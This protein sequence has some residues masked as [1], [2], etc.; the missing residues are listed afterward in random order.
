[1]VSPMTLNIRPSVS[2]PTG[3]WI[4]APVART[5]SPRRT[6]S[7]VSI[8]MHAHR[9][10]AEALLHLEHEA[11][12]ALAI[13]LERVENLRQ[14]LA[15]ELDVDDRTDHLHDGAGARFQ[16][17]NCHLSPQPS[18]AAAPET[19][20]INSVVIDACRTLL[21]VRVRSSMKSLALSDA[22]RIATM[23][24]ACSDGAFSSTAR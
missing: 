7:V 5:E 21:A 8:A 20:S 19:I 23:R 17:H 3:T 24:A 4:G 18:S 14:A 16:L 15:A 11:V 22:L 13:D 9:A 10:V 1:M 2:S 6:P 12:A